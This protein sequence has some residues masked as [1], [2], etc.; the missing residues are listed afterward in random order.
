MKRLLVATFAVAALLA[1]SAAL[2]NGVVLKVQRST[3]LVAVAHTAA[4]SHLR[5]GQRVA[6]SAR[7]L[8]NGTLAA[9]RV[10]VLGRAHTLRFRGLVL[11]RSRTKIVVSAGGAVVTVHRGS[12]ATASATDDAPK[13]GTTVDVT[14]TVGK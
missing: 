4:A 9:S 5:V 8:R 3:H 14:A 7:T 1:P 12:R 13:P 2:A 6:L 11:A 10:T